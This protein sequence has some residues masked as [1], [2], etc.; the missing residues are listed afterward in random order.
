LPGNK[1][2]DQCEVMACLWG[3]DVWS[4]AS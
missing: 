2:L 1:Q 3:C 4:R